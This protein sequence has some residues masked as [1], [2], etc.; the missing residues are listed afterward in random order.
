MCT[1][2]PP[3]R[4]FRRR[5]LDDVEPDEIWAAATAKLSLTLIRHQS[6]Y[7]KVDFRDGGIVSM[8]ALDLW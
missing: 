7:E 6:I 3:G 8:Q 5:S 2:H 4:S 1:L